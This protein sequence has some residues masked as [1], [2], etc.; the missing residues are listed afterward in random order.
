MLSIKF[1]NETI[2]LLFCKLTSVYL[3]TKQRS[4]M[5]LVTLGENEKPKP[6]ASNECC[7]GGACCPC[8][9]DT[10]F[11]QLKRWQE[12]QTPESKKAEQYVQPLQVTLSR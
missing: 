2:V 11:E 12:S 7:G 3:G 10:Y 5:S 6:P 1:R 8:V 9:W 4:D